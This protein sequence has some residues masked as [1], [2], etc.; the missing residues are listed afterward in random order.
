[1]LGDYSPMDSQRYVSIGD[2]NVYLVEDDPMEEF[3]V[4]LSN[5][6]DDDDI[7]YLEEEGT[8]TSIPLLRGYQL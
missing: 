4:E 1:M 3:D 7:P 6:L 8:T 5:M 2:G